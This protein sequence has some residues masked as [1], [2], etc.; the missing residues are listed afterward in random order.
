MKPEVGVRAA[1]CG[2]LI[3]S[4]G[5]ECNCWTVEEC[6][7]EEEKSLAHNGEQIAGGEERLD[8]PIELC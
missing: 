3:P 2:E 1:P 6:A 5:G 7:K 4:S 8:G